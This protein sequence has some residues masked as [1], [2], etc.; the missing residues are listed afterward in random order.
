MSTG[1]P[2]AGTCET[3]TPCPFARTER[4]AFVSTR[5]FY[6]EFDNREAVLVEITDRIVHAATEA[7]LSA[8]YEPGAD[9]VRREAT[10]RVR[11]LANSLRSKESHSFPPPPRDGFS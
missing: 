7:M 5:N 2:A 1:V 8:Q 10:A 4:P 3:T 9:R 6:E 11:S